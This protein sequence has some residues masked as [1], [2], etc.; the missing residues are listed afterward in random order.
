MHFLCEVR[1]FRNKACVRVID[2]R[3]WNRIMWLYPS[4]GGNF[5]ICTYISLY[6]QKQQ[7]LSKLQVR[8]FSSLT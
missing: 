1:L 4:P 2:I 3:E 8:V 7:Q 6:L 5:L